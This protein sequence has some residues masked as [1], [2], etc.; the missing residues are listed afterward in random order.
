MHLA[1]PRKRPEP[2]HGAAFA[3]RT[4]LTGP[5]PTE[6]EQAERAFG[7]EL[8]AFVDAPH[9]IPLSGART[10]LWHIL[11]WL[12]QEHGAGE[13]IL[14]ALTASIIPNV[15]LAAGFVP[16]FVDVHPRRFTA[17]ADALLAAVTDKTRALLPTH[18]EGF[19][20]HADRVMAALRGRPLLVI[21][22]AAHALGALVSGR[23]TGSLTHA[24]IFSL[25]KGKQLNCVEG[26]VVT[27]SNPS[28][29]RFL[30]AAARTAEAPSTLAVLKK[31]A[32]VQTMRAVTHPG[33][34]HAS[35]WPGLRLFAAFGKDPLVER[36]TDSLDPPGPAGP[37]SARR[38]LGAAQAII[39]RSALR[40]YPAALARRRG[41]WRRLATTARASGLQVQEPTERTD[42]APLELVLRV[43]DREAARA[44]LRRRGVD[45]Q[46]TWMMVPQ[47]LPAFAGIEP[48]TFPVAEDLARRLLYLPCYPGLRDS[49]VDRLE[50]LLAA[51]PAALRP[52]PEAPRSSGEEAA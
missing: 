29:A 21:E 40:H 30:E 27:T 43:D 6:I 22:D 34:F 50:A 46:P 36:F 33:L 42:P 19:P 51:P 25:G 48:G 15:V 45:A 4:L 9:A 28:L 10:G 23:P 41:I 18:L 20:V 14:P 16:R 37:T 1:I 39:G 5:A 44:A 26:G 11:A 52:P 31:I 17:G 7:R 13:V 32:M 38:R 35:L 12:K 24:A 2:L 3:L 49:E 8:A 47:Q